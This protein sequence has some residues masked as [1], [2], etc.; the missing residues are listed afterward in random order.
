M[1]T[2]KTNMHVNPLVR[3]L[4][5]NY[6]KFPKKIYFLNV[7]HFEINQFIVYYKLHECKT[8]KICDL[9]SF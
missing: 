7:I 4:D 5:F 3:V 8:C 6:I 9:N 1:K 2:L